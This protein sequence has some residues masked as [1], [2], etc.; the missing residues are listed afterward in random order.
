MGAVLRAGL[1]VGRDGAGIVVRLHHDEAGPEDHQEGEQ[2]T[3][4]KAA[5]S[6]TA[7]RSGLVENLGNRVFQVSGKHNFPRF[8][9]LR[10]TSAFPSLSLIR[11]ALANDPSAE[12]ANTRR[13]PCPPKMPNC[14]LATAAALKQ[15]DGIHI[16]KRSS[17]RLGRTQAREQSLSTV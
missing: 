3:R 9:R 12:A 15:A 14:N 2:I 17:P 10:F 6:P 4:A 16:A 11:P 1:H 5:D 8:S 13:E 7:R